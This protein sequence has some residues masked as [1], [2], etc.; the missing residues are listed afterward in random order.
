MG[1]KSGKGFFDYSDRDLRDV[2][3]DARRRPHRGLRPVEGPDRQAHLSAGAAC[4]VIDRGIDRPRS[5]SESTMKLPTR[6][7]HHHGVAQRRVRDQ[8]HEPQRAGAAGRDR[9]RGARVLQRRR[10]DR[11]HPRPRRAGQAARHEGEV[12]GDPRRRQRR[13]PATSSSSSPPAAAPTSPSR[14]ACRAWTPTP[15]WPRSTWAR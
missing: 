6:Q 12:R 9:P 14:S 1:V 3:K 2:L 8:G 5:E 15:R 13:V 7:G 11:P 4:E 10:G